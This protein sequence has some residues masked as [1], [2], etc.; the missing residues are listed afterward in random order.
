MIIFRII[1]LY[2]V[3]LDNFGVKELRKAHDHTSKKLK[4]MRIFYC[5]NFTLE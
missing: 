1:S 4:Y 2:T 3:D 5:D